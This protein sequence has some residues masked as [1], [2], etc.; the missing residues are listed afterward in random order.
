MATLYLT[1]QGS[2]LCKD[3]LRLVVEK[4]DQVLLEVPEFKVE[5]VLV[6]G[7]VQLTTQAINFLLENGIETSF[8]T[9]SGRLRGKLSPVASKNVPLRLAQYERSRDGGF[10]LDLSRRIVEGK[11]KNARA[12][13][14]RYA[15]NHPEVDFSEAVGEIDRAIQALPRKERVSTVLGVEGTAIG[16]YFRAYGR[17]FR[18]GLGF[19]RR[20]RRP[21]GDPVNALLSFGYVLITNEIGS[22]VEAMGFDPYI[23]F[24]HAPEYGRK[25]LAL[26]L[27]EEFR[28]P[29]VDGLT[30]SLINTRV[31]GEEDFEHREDGG[32]YLKREANR[33]FF[34]HYERRMNQTF[35]DRSLG[36]Q[37]SFRE[38]FKVQ[39][40]RLAKT[41]KDGEPYQPFQ[42]R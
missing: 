4:D 22:L 16:T 12:L 33:K 13:L 19:E 14:G 17:M 36:R 20:I 29:V 21:P 32:F 18:K 40:Q 42:V 34:T 24:L 6:F 41:V 37:A 9:L 15:R 8:L 31:L 39:A 25:S 7:N 11:L 38:L 2:K 10:K 27:V 35:L 28:H 3:H 5:R 26:D 23:G 30:L 1:E